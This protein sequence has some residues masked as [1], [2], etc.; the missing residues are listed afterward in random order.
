MS[1]TG[2]CALD[3]FLGQM[4]KFSTD[5]NALSKLIFSATNKKNQQKE[6]RSHYD[7]GNN[8]YKLWLGILAD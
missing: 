1:K 7:L 6:V 3:H 4:G 2:L 5:R 8:F